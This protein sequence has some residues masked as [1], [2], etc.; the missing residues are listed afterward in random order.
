MSASERARRRLRRPSA[1][2]ATRAELSAPPSLW[3]MVRVVALSV[4]AIILI[5][6]A[7]G[8]AFG[9]LLM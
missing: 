5:S 8:Y 1:R 4:A 2:R 7:A 9:R 6:F 3:T